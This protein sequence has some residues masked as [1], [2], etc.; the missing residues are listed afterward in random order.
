[1][2]LLMTHRCAQD[3]AAR[4]ERRLKI[5][6]LCAGVPHCLAKL[7]GAHCEMRTSSLFPKLCAVD[8]EYG[9]LTISLQDKSNRSD[10]KSEPVVN[11][12]CAATLATSSFEA[13]TQPRSRN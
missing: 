3:L 8:L 4:L 6:I 9:C 1:G 11:P 10:G 2:S 5:D 12:G 7:C 13:G